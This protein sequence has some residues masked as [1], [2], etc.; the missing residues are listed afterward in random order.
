MATPFIHFA[1]VTLIRHKG[2]TI[3]APSACGLT[4]SDEPGSLGPLITSSR[5]LANCPDC[6]ARS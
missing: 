1:P 4:C 3:V 6:E 5:E 2:N